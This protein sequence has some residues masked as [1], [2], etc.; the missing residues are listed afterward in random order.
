MESSLLSDEKIADLLLNYEMVNANRKV[1]NLEFVR[2]IAKAQD[3]K[4]VKAILEWGDGRCEE[5]GYRFTGMFGKKL[6]P[7]RFNCPICMKALEESN[8]QSKKI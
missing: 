5:H 2:F 3:T 8:E 6:Y 1:S 4:S 7:N